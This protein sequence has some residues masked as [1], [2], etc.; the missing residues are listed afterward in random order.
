MVKW[1]QVVLGSTRKGT[2][3]SGTQIA[4]KTGRTSMAN[5]VGSHLSC[6]AA[7]AVAVSLL[8]LRC[9]HGAGGDIPPSWEVEG[10]QSWC[11]SVVFV[12]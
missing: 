6:A 11:R 10:D 8:D 9:A 5:E 3:K 12:M 2:I 1:D 4:P 7:K